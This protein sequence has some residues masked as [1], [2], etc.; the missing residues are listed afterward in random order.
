MMAIAAKLKSDKRKFYDWMSALALITIFLILPKVW[1]GE[2]LIL[3][4]S[5]NDKA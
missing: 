1:E 4:G 3:S 2:F 5:G